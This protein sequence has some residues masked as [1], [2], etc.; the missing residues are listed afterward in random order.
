MRAGE[1][2]VSFVGLQKAPFSVI[3]EILTTLGKYPATTQQRD[4]RVSLPL[5]R[6]MV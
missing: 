2:R 1:W 6:D 4:L 5:E 3:Q